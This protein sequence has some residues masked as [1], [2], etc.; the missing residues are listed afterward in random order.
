MLWATWKAH[1]VMEQYLWHHFYEHP[2]ISAVLAWHLAD[3]YVKHDNTHSSQ[4][5]TLEK[6]VKSMSTHIDKLEHVIWDVKNGNNKNLQD[7]KRGGRQDK[8]QDCK[9]QD[10]LSL[11]LGTLEISAC[12][13]F[14]FCA[15]VC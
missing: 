12:E 1:G 2:S 4:L 9:H 14:C 11:L 5:T 15:I 10:W 6:L 13:P 3:H 8:H 7:G